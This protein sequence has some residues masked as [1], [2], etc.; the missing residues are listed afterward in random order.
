M[1]SEEKYTGETALKLFLQNIKHCQPN[2]AK[3]SGMELKINNK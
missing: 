3:S 2:P 1:S